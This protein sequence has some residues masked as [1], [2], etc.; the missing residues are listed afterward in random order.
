M[1]CQIW[2]RA[3]EII[4]PTIAAGY[5]LFTQQ[6]RNADNDLD[7]D[8]RQVHVLS[9]EQSEN[10]SNTLN[11]YQLTDFMWEEPAIGQDNSVMITS[12]TR[13]VDTKLTP[14]IENASVEQCISTLSHVIENGENDLD[15]ICDY[16]H[17]Q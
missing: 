15:G 12:D 8:V 6:S 4:R 5:M 7:G 3:Q 11:A 9:K 1:N 14:D 16:L 17:V 13:N 10:V 2:P